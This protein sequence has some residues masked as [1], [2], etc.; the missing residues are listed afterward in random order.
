MPAIAGL[1]WVAAGNQEFNPGLPRTGGNPT[2][3]AI[4]AAAQ[5]LH[6]R[7]PDF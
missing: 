6:Y 3:S 2:T 1:G 7:K 5:G 4:T